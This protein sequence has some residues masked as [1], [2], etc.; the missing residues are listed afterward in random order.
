MK[1]F[2][3]ISVVPLLSYS[4]ISEIYT[5]E[6]ISCETVKSLEDKGVNVV[7]AVKNQND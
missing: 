7:V 4:E 5:D 2:S 1:K 3:Q 6:E